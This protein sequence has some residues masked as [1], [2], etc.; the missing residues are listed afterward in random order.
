MIVFNRIAT[1]KIHDPKLCIYEMHKK[2]ENLE[3]KKDQ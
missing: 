2:L 3:E 1:L